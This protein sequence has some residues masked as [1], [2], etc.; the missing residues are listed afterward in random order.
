M[1]DEPNIPVIANPHAPDVFADAAASFSLMGGVVRI[2]FT[3]VR[4]TELGG[5]SSH[6]V[7]GQLAMPLEG[8]Q[9]LAVGLFD[10]LKSRGEFPSGE[11][12]Q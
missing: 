6:V 3:A 7:I 9:G 8:A 5:A 12:A 1:A 4:P 11:T 2:A 10:F